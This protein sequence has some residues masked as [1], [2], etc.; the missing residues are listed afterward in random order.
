MFEK[1]TNWK[2]FLNEDAKNILAN[3]FETTKKHRCAYMQ[4]EDVKH[5][6]LWCALIELKKDVAGMTELLSKIEAPFKA[7]VAIGEAEKRKAIEKFVT[8]IVRPEEDEEKKA[9][10]KL[11]ESLM[12]F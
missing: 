1:E 9:T 12:K 3:I 4:A 10:Q 11:V 8:E 7:I 2:E 6:Q 5:A